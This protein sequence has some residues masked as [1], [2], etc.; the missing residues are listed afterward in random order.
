[1]ASFS[2]KSYQRQTTIISEQAQC[3]LS[4]PTKTLTK[5]SQLCNYRD[6]FVC[7]I[8]HRKM[9]LVQLLKSQFV[10][11]LI[12]CYVFMASGLIVNVLQLLTLPLWL[13]SKQLARRVNI[14]LGYCIMSRKY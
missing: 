7:V 6:W 9:G 5:H 2:N 14:R 4:Q 13:V 8:L 1:M 3:F 11:H 10:F 12:I